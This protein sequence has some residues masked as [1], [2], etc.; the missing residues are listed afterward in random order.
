MLISPIIIDKILYVN[1]HA[2]QSFYGT[3]HADQLDISK[4]IVTG[5]YAEELNLTILENV[6]NFVKKNKS[7]F[8]VLVLEFQKLSTA[9][10]N[11]YEVLNTIRNEM[12]FLILKN[13]NSIIIEKLLLNDC[14]GY[15]DNKTDTTFH[16]TFLLDEEARTKKHL[17]KEIKEVFDAEFKTKL[18]SITIENTEKRI[19]H[20][21]SV[22]LNKFID[23]KKLIVDYKP[24]FLY[25]CYWLALEMNSKKLKRTWAI[26]KG[27]KI[28]LLCQN[29]NSSFISSILSSFLLLDVITLDH[30]GPINKVYNE[31]ESKINHGE[32]YL[33][34]S[35]VVCMGTEV[36][37]AKNIIEF[38]GGKYIGNV[39]LIRI[40]P[41]ELNEKY[42]DI[43]SVFEITKTNNPINFKITTALD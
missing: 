41:M 37:I 7:E 13:V 3:F 5:I 40:L 17:V 27:S 33:V 19:H 11:L 35:D 43:E 24:L 15:F 14:L 39:C 25:S 30:I 20:S 26:E 4:N 12:K 42:R 28:T 31:I 18:D 36:R 34:I 16:D 10:K 9:Q 6:L 21:S 32:E 2:E 22:Y 1:L 8:N 29:L 23:I 38:S